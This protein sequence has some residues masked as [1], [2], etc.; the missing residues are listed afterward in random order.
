MCI[1][2]KGRC[3]PDKPVLTQM[4]LAESALWAGP[5]SQGVMP[6]LVGLIAVAVVRRVPAS[7]REANEIRADLTVLAEV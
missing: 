1:K 3:G 2:E 7:T 6:D 4:A 5:G